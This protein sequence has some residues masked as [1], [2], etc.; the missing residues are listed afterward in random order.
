MRGTGCAHNC[1]RFRARTHIKN[2]TSSYIKKKKFY[3]RRN[4]K[5]E[6][7]LIETADISHVLSSGLQQREMTMIP[8]VFLLIVKI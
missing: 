5:L 4:N 2:V 3:K 7:S 1:T 6:F 8:D